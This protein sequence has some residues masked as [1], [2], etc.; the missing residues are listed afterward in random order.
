MNSNEYWQKREDEALKHYIKDEA[1]YDREI[2]RIYRNMLDNCQKEIDAFYGRYA[3]KENITIAE[4]KKKIAKLD[5]EAYERK[6]KR[7]VKEKD[8]SKTANEEMRLYNATMRIN[9]LEL[10]KANLGLEIIAGHNELESFLGGVLKGRTMAEL[11]RQ[12]GILGKTVLHNTKKADAIVNASFHNATFSNRI[13]QYQ[14]LMKADLSKL[15]Q[16]GLIQGKNPRAL[17]KDLK[18]Y[19]IGAD[20]KGGAAYNTERLMRTELAR[21]QTEAQKQ[22]FIRNG[23]DKYIFIV[24]GGCCE[25]C[26]EI[27][28]KDSGFGKGVYLVE[29]MMPGLNAS[30]AHPHC[31]CSTAAW[32]D[33]TEYEAWLDG[34]ANGSGQTWKDAKEWTARKTAAMRRDPSKFKQKTA[35][36]QKEKGFIK[37]KSLEEALNIGKA[38]VKGGSFTVDGLHLNTVNGFNEAMYNVVQRF[39]KKLNISGLKPVKKTDAAYMQGSY[40]PR[41]RTIQLKGGNSANALE[42]FKKHREKYF[43]NGWLS[44]NEAYGT[45]Y[46]EI[47]HAL[48][49]DLP[50]SAKTEIRDLYQTTKHSAYK[51]WM[52]MGGSGSGTSQAEIF[53]KSLSRYAISDEQEFFSEAFAQ[54]MAGRMRPVSRQVNAVLNK[55]LR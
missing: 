16:S 27:A 41:S 7:Y 48:W 19:F 8:F 49:T 44:S 50:S 38:Y 24:N 37:A 45:F 22:S 5:I 53:G 4:A 31:R 14:D 13:W 52:E 51:N 47:G 28:K 34:L 18:K 6:A 10:L 21:V 39:G 33:S 11:K 20:G 55:H 12:A 35:T 42:S 3:A 25:K 46:H 17:A 15:L 54:I 32:E 9:R 23:F 36:E 1:E 40:D 43:A 30:P 26:E 29:D 2:R